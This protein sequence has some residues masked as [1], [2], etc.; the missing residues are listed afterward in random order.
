MGLGFRVQG[1][2]GCW[3]LCL[4]VLDVNTGVASR[5]LGGT[6]EDGELVWILWLYATGLGVQGFV[7]KLTITKPYKP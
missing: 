5:F 7:F 6:M 2:W 4:W 1:V 3:F